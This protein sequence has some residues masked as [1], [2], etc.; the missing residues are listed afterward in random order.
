MLHKIQFSIMGDV[1]NAMLPSLFENI[2]HTFH[3][4][5]V[6]HTVPPFHTNTVDFFHSQ[7]I[8]NSTVIHTNPV[9]HT[10]LDGTLE[11]VFYT[12]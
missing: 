2:Y 11:Y 5:G 12:I 7:C 4:H 3:S 9:H 10:F 6:F 8:Q 1:V